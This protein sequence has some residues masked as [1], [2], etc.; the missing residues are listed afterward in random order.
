M[1]SLYISISLLLFIT[2]I[3]VGQYYFYKHWGNNYVFASISCGTS[4]SSTPPPA[5]TDTST[6]TQPGSDS[7]SSTSSCT[8][9][10]SAPTVGFT[11]TSNGAALSVSYAAI[12]NAPEYVVDWWFNDATK[13]SSTNKTGYQECKKIVTTTSTT[14]SNYDNSHANKQGTSTSECWSSNYSQTFGVVYKPIV[15]SCS[16]I[17]YS[18]KRNFTPNPQSNLTVVDRTFGTSPSFTVNLAPISLTSGSVSSYYVDWWFTDGSYKEWHTSTTKPGQ[19]TISPSTVGADHYPTKDSI[20]VGIAY[21]AQS[22]C[23]GLYSNKAT[24]IAGDG[25][26]GGSSGNTASLKLVVGLPGIGFDATGGVTPHHMTR[27][28]TVELYGASVANPSGPGTTPLTTSPGTISYDSGSDNNAGYFTGTV[29]VQIPTTPAANNAY[30][31]LVKIPQYLYQ[32]AVNVAPADTSLPNVFVLTKGASA[33]TSPFILHAGDVAVTSGEANK[34]D[35]EDYTI[36]L[37][38]YGQ[39]TNSS[40]CLVKPANSTDLNPADLNDDGVVDIVDLNIWTRSLSDLQQGQ[41]T[42]C[43]GLTCQGQ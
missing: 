42:S 40:S 27:K 1:K 38:C 37:G 22:P 30:Q 36:L 13:I 35:L 15:S 6:Q 31:V 24:S 32:L 25:S 29:N 16:N 11:C 20:S 10:T 3:L 39:N 4:C 7:Q 5:H 34:L 2:A 9:P 28:V 41:S 14:I 33:T 8:A 21:K 26:G 12:D 18:P 23:S 19:L 43:T 17:A